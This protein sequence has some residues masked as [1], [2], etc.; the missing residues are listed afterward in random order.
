MLGSCSSSAKCCD[1]LTCYQGYCCSTTGK[2]C[3]VTI[4]CCYLSDTCVAGACK[5]SGGTGGSGGSG[6]TG[7]K[8][9][10]AGTGGSGGSC[11]PMLGSC[12]ASAKCCTPLTCYLGYCCSTTGQPCGVDI[13]C[14]YASEHCIAGKCK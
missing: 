7:G 9:G 10:S 1:P 8:A 6:G 3:G 14:C 11:V 2:P 13:D 5:G 12:S 4:D